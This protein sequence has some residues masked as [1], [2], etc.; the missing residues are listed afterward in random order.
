MITR[1][2][3]YRAGRADALALQGEAGKLTGTEIIARE[4]EVPDFVPGKDY[5]SWPVGAPVSDD[6]QVWTLIQ[7]HNAADYQGRP[8]TLRA[9]WGLAHTTDPERA[10]PWVEPLGTSGMYMVGECYRVA[11]GT[12]YRCLQDNMVY[13]AEAL[14]SAWEVVPL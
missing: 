14:P 9:L 11:D 2:I 13:D 3:L 8:S 7:P 6:G 1:E 12:V 10:K 5:T 4:G